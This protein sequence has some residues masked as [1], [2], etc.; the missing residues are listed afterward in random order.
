M[1][2]CWISAGVS[3]FIAGVLG[4]AD[5][6]IYIDVADQHPDS[7]RFIKDCEKALGKKIEIIRNE[8]FAN[9]TQVFYR[10]QFIVS[11]YGAP[12]T[13]ELKKAV[14]R[15]WETDY[16]REHGTKEFLDLVYIWGYDAEEKKRKEKKRFLPTFQSLSMNSL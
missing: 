7:M 11:P 8:D 10:R 2:V 4:K 3:S 16:L 12:C 13:Q 5:K 14:R 9:T 15:K 6:Y 1:K